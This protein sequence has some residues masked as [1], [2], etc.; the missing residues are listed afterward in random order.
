MAGRLRAERITLNDVLSAQSE[1]TF[2]FY[3]AL[4]NNRCPYCGG[5]LRPYGNKFEKNV[6]C[7]NDLVCDFC[8]KNFGMQFKECD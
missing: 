3:D 5:V 7:K 4:K 2:D 1:S 6:S 8:G